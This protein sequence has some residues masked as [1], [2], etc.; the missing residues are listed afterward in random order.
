MVIDI[1]IFF[2]G[3]VS[4]EVTFLSVIQMN[5]IIY[6][7]I[8]SKTCKKLSYHVRISFYFV[9]T[10]PIFSFLSNT[11]FQVIL[12]NISIRKLS[13][14]GEQVPICYSGSRNI[15]IYHVRCYP[16]DAITPQKVEIGGVST[17]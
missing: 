13:R 6:Q 1:R 9:E 17:K 3:L 8:F 10:P 11:I 14:S 16:Q 2:S 5:P 15:L 12:N 4:V 7:F